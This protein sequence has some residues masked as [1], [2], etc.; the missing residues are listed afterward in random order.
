MLKTRVFI[1]VSL[2]ISSYCIQPS[3]AGTTVTQINPPLPPAPI[4]LTGNS[5][6]TVSSN[7]GNISARPS[8]II[9][10]PQSLPYLRLTAESEGKPTLLIDGPGGR[11]CVQSD[12]YS[13][14][15][16]ELSG[17]WQQGKYSLYVGDLSQNQYNYTLSISQHKK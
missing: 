2:V 11:F 9:E 14:H 17:Y 16:A 1:V 8:Q 10:L 3:L 12:S 15:K 13:D 5:G 4:I 6:G 7:C